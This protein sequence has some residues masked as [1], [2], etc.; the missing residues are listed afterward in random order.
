MSLEQFYL[1]YTTAEDFIGGAKI[2]AR[3]ING[4]IDPRMKMMWAKWDY[5]TRNVPVDKGYKYFDINIVSGSLDYEFSGGTN[6]VVFEATGPDYTITTDDEWLHITGGDGT[7]EITADVNTGETRT[8]YVCAQ[9][10]NAQFQL[11]EKCFEARQ[12]QDYASMYFTLEAL[13]AGTLSFDSTY[14]SS[15]VTFYY[16]KNNESWVG[17]PF[18]ESIDITVD[19]GDL[20]KMKANTNSYYTPNP[21]EAGS[22]FKITPHFNCNAYGNILSLIYGDSFRNYIVLPSNSTYAFYELFKNSYIVSAKNVIMPANVRDACYR[23]MFQGCTSLTT[24]PALPATTL[25]GYCYESM[26]KNCTSLVNAP[27][28]PATTLAKGCYQSMFQG[29]TSLTT[30]PELP[31]TTLAHTCYEGMFA[32]CTSLTNAPNLPAT[33]LEYECYLSMFA[34]C[35]SLTV[36]P[37]LPAVVMDTGCYL[38]MFSGCTSLVTAPALPATTLANNCYTGM[39]QGCT[40]LVNAPALPATALTYGCYSNMFTKCTSLQYIKC[41]AETFGSASVNSWVYGVPSGGTFVKKAGVTWRSGTS[42]IPNGWT[43]QEE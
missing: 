13:S 25:A 21:N 28:L 40:S 19:S 29:C 34:N 11:E 36:T 16:K 3:P 5:I 31:A 8:G 41:L 7:Y 38:R 4:H 42:G 2:T 23:G 20:I 33:A 39:F 9:W 1:Q 37:E 32:N 30:A 10:Y 6:T 12:K 26:L 15:T 14:S 43:V 18:T 24:A 27:V 22:G 17:I 35:T